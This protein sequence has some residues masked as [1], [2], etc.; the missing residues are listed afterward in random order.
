MAIERRAHIRYEPTSQVDARLIWKDATGPHQSSALLSD[1]SWG[2]CALISAHA[3]LVDSVAL[4]SVVLVAGAVAAT[5]QCRVLS[6]NPLGD[7]LLV[8]TRFEQISEQQVSQLKAI[9][10]SNA[11]RPLHPEAQASRRMH[12]RVPQWAAYMTA[13][14]IPVAPK[15]KLALLSAESD[16]GGGLSIMELADLANGDPFLCLSLLREAEEKRT[17]RLGHETT[18]SLAAVMQVGTD[19]FR[20]LLLSLPETDETRSGLVECQSR[21]VLAGRVAAAWCKLRFDDAP[22]EVLMAALLSEM[23]ELLLWHFAPELPQSTRDAMAAGEAKRTAE[24]QQACCGFKFQDLTLKCIEDW[25]LPR[26]LVQLIRGHDN[27]R[28]KLGRVATDAARHLIAGPDNPALLDDLVMAKQ[29]L[30]HAITME[31]VVDGLQVIPEDMRQ[32]LTER[33]AVALERATQK[34]P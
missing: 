24:A 32:D 5:F 28:A 3:P 17:A 6:C 15:S 1:I 14:R 21:A 13:Q 2:G 30:P 7:T 33:A 26:L 20:E 10:G 9:L 25:R 34:G 11:Y 4:V 29:L 8:S 31:R 22:D 16:E 12:W 18:T 19:A 23:G 27:V